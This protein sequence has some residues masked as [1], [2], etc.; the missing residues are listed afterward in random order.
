MA[1]EAAVPFLG[2]IPIDPKVGVDSDK[3]APFVISHKDSAAA[4]AFMDFVAKV[5]DYLNT[6][7]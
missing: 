2:S 4:K 1:Q 6:K 7:K 5:E 3:G